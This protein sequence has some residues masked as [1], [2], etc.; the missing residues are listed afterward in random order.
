MK[1]PSVLVQWVS[2]YREMGAE[3]LKPQRKGR[4]PKMAKPSSPKKPKNEQEAY[5]KRLEEENYLLRLELDCLKGLRRLRLE[6]EAAQKK[7]QG[8]HTASEDPID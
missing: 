8:S 4:Y 3:G 6:E 2:R 5:L 7:K 1:A